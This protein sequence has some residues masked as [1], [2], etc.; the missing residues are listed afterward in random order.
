MYIF[1]LRQENDPKA[2]DI[3]KVV[4]RYFLGLNFVKAKQ[5]MK[6]RVYHLTTTQFTLKK[7]A[8]SLQL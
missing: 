7:N 5:K 6:I 1:I 8:I 4:Q 2:L 3:L